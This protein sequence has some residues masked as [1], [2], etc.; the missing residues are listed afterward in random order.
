MGWGEK[1]SERVDN[2]KCKYGKDFMKIKF[3]SDE[4]LLLNKLLN[5]PLLT[6]IVRSVFEDEGRFYPQVCLDERLYELWV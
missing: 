1:K 5:L 3:D 2:G 4:N 6:I